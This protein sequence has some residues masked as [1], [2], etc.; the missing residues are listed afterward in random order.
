MWE[1]WCNDPCGFLELQFRKALLF[2]DGR[3]IPNNVSLEHDG[4]SGSLILKYLIFGRNHFLLALAAGGMLWFV[5]VLAGKRKL[6]GVRMLYAFVLIFY[7]SVVIFYILS[8]F[9]APVLP[10]LLL[11]GGGAL[12]EWWD[13]WRKKQWKPRMYVIITMLAGVWLS[14]RAY[15]L[16]RD[17]EAGI[18]RFIHPDG[19]ILDMRGTDILH[20]DHGPKPFGG[21]QDVEVIPELVIEKHFAKVKNS[22]VELQLMMRNQDAAAIIMSINGKILRFELPAQLPGK[23]DRRMVRLPV[24]VVDGR[25]KLQIYAVSGGKIYFTF[26]SQRNYGRSRINGSELAGEWVMRAGVRKNF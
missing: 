12:C 18:Q 17:C 19:I 3:E 4:C 25:I 24:Q 11:F 20:F 2:W 10:L 16:Y 26:D 7:I 14:T 1:W 22:P 23:S 15:D 5:P 21:W 8:R 9:K 13:I 6:P